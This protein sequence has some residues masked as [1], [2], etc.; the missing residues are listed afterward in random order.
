MIKKNNV[1][2]REEGRG[3]RLGAAAMKKLGLKTHFTTTDIFRSQ[4]L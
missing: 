3:S 2:K 1:E 4:F